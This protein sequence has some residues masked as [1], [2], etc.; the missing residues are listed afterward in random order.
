MADRPIITEADRA[1]IQNRINQSL[2][3]IL[4]GSG[5]Y[6]TDGGRRS[7]GE[8]FKNLLDYRL[9]LPT[10]HDVDDPVDI[11]RSMLLDFD[12]RIRDLQK[13]A[14]GPHKFPDSPDVIPPFRDDHFEMQPRGPFNPQ[15]SPK[16][17]LNQ[18]NDPIFFESQDISEAGNEAAAPL[19]P[20]NRRYLSRPIAGQA[21]AFDTGAPAVPFIPPNGTRSPDRASSFDNRFGASPPWLIPVRRV[22]RSCASCRDIGDQPLRMGQPRFCHGKQ[23]WLCPWLSQT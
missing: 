5:A 9:S 1:E 6:W 12:E 15:P 18:F 19:A 7:L 16:D 23:L 17:L 10:V 4:N 22:L 21:S 2:D 3:Y 13:A 11:Y 8:I 20:D 14:P